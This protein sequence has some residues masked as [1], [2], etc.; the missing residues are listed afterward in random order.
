MKTPQSTKGSDNPDRRVAS[1][2]RRIA[3]GIDDRRVAIADSRPAG[4][5]VA[6]RRV[7]TEDRRIAPRKKVRTGGRISGPDG[8]PVECTVRNISDTGASL[9]VHNPALL[10]AFELAFDDPQWPARSCSV[11]WRDGIRIGVKFK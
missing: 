1:K 9:E 3:D 8:D 10:D 5:R 11:V 6:E 2:E 7:A 4:K